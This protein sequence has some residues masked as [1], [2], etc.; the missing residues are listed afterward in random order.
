MWRDLL[1]EQQI[2]GKNFL[3]ECERREE[4][5][6]QTLLVGSEFYEVEKFRKN[7]QEA[8]PEQVFPFEPEAWFAVATAKINV[9]KEFENVIM[10]ELLEAVQGRDNDRS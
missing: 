7:A 3:N 6:F 4:S 9:L 2:H 5:S 8:L 10:A 1:K